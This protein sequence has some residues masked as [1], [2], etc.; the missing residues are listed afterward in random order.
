MGTISHHQFLALVTAATVAGVLGTDT[1]ATGDSRRVQG[2]DCG[3]GLAGAALTAQSAREQAIACDT[4][5][6]VSN[7]IANSGQLATQDEPLTIEAGGVAWSCLNR[8]T[9]DKE[10]EY[11]QCANGAEQVTLG[12]P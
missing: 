1:S 4:A 5:H 12:R 6:E 7:A 11:T 8:L 9:K 3:T 10:S 2:Y